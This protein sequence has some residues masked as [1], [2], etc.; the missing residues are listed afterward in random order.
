MNGEY[1]EFNKQTFNFTSNNCYIQS[2]ESLT[3]NH[4]CK[5]WSIEE[6]GAYIKTNEAEETNY[7]GIYIASFLINANLIKQGKL[8]VT[9]VNERIPIEETVQSGKFIIYVNHSKAFEDYE[10][11]PNEEEEEIDLT[12]GLTSILF[13]FQKQAHQLD[14]FYYNSS[15]LF[16]KILSIE[17]TGIDNANSKCIPCYNGFCKEGSDRCFYCNKG[18]YLDKTSSKCIKCP[19][20]TTTSSRLAL[21]SS[22]CQSIK[23][24]DETSY[25]KNVSSLCHSKTNKRLVTYT[26]KDRNCIES[27]SSLAS[28]KKKETECVQCLIGQFKY[29]I[30][31][32]YTKCVNCPQGTYSYQADSPHCSLCKDGAISKISHHKPQLYSS[33]ES[34]TINEEIEGSSGELTIQYS[35]TNNSAIVNL[36]IDSL[37]AVSITEPNQI[38]Q[39]S[40]GKHTINVK[41]NNSTLINM[42]SITNTV[43]GTGYKCS[44]HKLS[45]CPPGTEFNKTAN[46]CSKCLDDKFNAHYGGKCE[47]CPIFTIPSR[48]NVHCSMNE[49]ISH[50]PSNLQFDLSLLKTLTSS[51]CKTNQSMCFGNNYYGPITSK[52]EQWSYFFISMNDALIF[53]SSVD[54]PNGNNSSAIGLTK[55]FPINHSSIETGFIYR[56]NAIEHFTFESIDNLGSEMNSVTIVNED[57]DKGIIIKYEN[58]DKCHANKAKRYQT[59]MYIKCQKELYQSNQ[60]R[61]T[62]KDDNDCTY[63]F[64][65]FSRIGCPIC[66]TTEIKQIKSNCNRKAQNVFNIIA[67]NN[68]CVLSNINGKTISESNDD[69]V[70]LNENKDSAL[71]KIYNI[72]MKRDPN[73]T[74]NGTIQKNGLILV[75]N[76]EIELQ[77]TDEKEIYIV[78]IAI[79]AGILLLLIVL[80]IIVYCKYSNLE[81][82]YQP[83]MESPVVTPPNDSIE[84]NKHDAN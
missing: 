25:M 46:Q 78:L 77:C 47:S 74:I 54:I 60:M 6:D 72:S 40:K 84:Q 2:N 59:F 26:L 75:E 83:L 11:S 50:P 3:R 17:I 49:I 39:L 55:K 4:K 44:N 19:I 52:I 57:N 42:I 81:K 66:K 53:S 15:Q 13:E 51:L 14:D 33:F 5:G 22:A 35:D 9:Y 24:C 28:L 37:T 79:A 7:A 31:E 80:F 48:D 10:F 1:L 23:E 70:L 36:I 71:I 76:N 69:G 8:K 16:M 32:E 56:G 64:E 67:A 20:G 18:E 41:G 30:N 27:Q 45:D 63:Y 62:A 21:N 43:N 73:K 65:F 68:D 61:L 58:G 82:V 12:Q 38:V 34:F 29:N